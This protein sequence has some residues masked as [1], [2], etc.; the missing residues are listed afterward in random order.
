MLGFLSGLYRRCVL[1]SRIIVTF[2]RVRYLFLRPLFPSHDA[3][4]CMCEYV[5]CCAR[6]LLPIGVSLP[7]FPDSYALCDDDC[8]DANDDDDD[9][10]SGKL[11]M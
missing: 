8:D 9:H 6:S 3:I 11:S 5:S 7:S 1:A 4:L 2:K 10:V